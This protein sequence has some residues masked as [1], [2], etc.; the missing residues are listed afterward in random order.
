VIQVDS[1]QGQVDEVPVGKV[2]A[3]NEIP[4]DLPLNAET[5]VQSGRTLIV[6]LDP[7]ISPD[8]ARAQALRVSKARGI[9]ADQANQLIAQFT[10][11][12]T[13]DLL[14]DPRVS[15]L[16]LNLALDQQFPRK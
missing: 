15:V 2:G 5:R 8:S 6:G 1:A 11:G 10:E 9:S 3:Q 16:K 4:G 14:G 13:F 12:P 7:H